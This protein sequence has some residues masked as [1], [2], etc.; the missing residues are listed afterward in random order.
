[1]SKISGSGSQSSASPNGPLE[2]TVEGK[3]DMQ[4]SQLLVMTRQRGRLR[5]GECPLKTLLS[6]YF[7]G[8]IVCSNFQSKQMLAV[9]KPSMQQQQLDYLGAHGGQIFEKP[10]VKTKKE[11]QTKALG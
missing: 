3:G 1:M 6:D 8:N 4:N 9:P 11:T 7:E 2:S 10:E 5:W